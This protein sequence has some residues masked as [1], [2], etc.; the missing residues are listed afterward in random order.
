MSV[1][2]RGLSVRRQ[3][4]VVEED[5]GEEQD[6]NGEEAA[7]EHLEE[8][9]GGVFRTPAPLRKKKDVE[10]VQEERIMV[11]VRVRPL[12]ESERRKGNTI[13]WRWDDQEIVTKE[14]DVAGLQESELIAGI[15]DD[16]KSNFSFDRVFGPNEGNSEI[17]ETLVRPLVQRVVEGFNAAIL[18]Y[19]QTT[20]GK[21]YTISG[22][23]TTKGIVELA[24][25]DLFATIRSTEVSNEFKFV[26]RISYFEIYQ[27]VIQDLLDEDK[28]HLSVSADPYRGPR[29]GG[30][31]EVVVTSAGQALDILKRGQGSRKVGRTDMSD[32]SSRSHAIFQIVV[33]SKPRVLE[34]LMRETS[35]KDQG[36][37]SGMN[38]VENALRSWAKQYEKPVA[39]STLS[40]IDLAGSERVSKSLAK[41]ERLKEAGHI[42]KSLAELGNVIADINAGKSYVPFRNSKL[43]RLLSGA[44]GGNSY[45]A[46]IC[47]ISP[48]LIHH[49]E[50]RSTLQFAQR[51]SKVKT[52]AKVN[53][54]ENG[55]DLLDAFKSQ[56]DS[57]QRRLALN[58]NEKEQL[59]KQVSALEAKLSASTS[60]ETKSLRTP[61]VSRRQQFLPHTSKKVSSSRLQ[62]V[63]FAAESSISTDDEILEHI[64]ALEKALDEKEGKLRTA[65]SHLQIAQNNLEKLAAANDSDEERI[66][67]L[68]HRCAELEQSLE[69]EGRLSQQA[70]TDARAQ[71]QRHHNAVEKLEEVLRERDRA[72]EKALDTENELFKKIEELSELKANAEERQQDRGKLLGSLEALEQRVQNLLL[73]RKEEV[74]DLT[75]SMEELRQNLDEARMEKRNVEQ[76]LLTLQ[77]RFQRAT[78]EAEKLRAAHESAEAEKGTICENLESLREEVSAKNASAKELRGVVSR[79]EREKLELTTTNQSYEAKLTRL[80]EANELSNRE[81]QELEKEKDELVERIALLENLAVQVE[82]S[83][84]KLEALHAERER[85]LERVAQL[86][87]QNADLEKSRLHRLEALE[88]EKKNLLARLL[89][90]EQEKSEVQENCTKLESDFASQSV[91]VSKLQRRI[92]QQERDLQS[93]QEEKADAIL[94]RDRLGKE[95]ST[96][97]KH[98]QEARDAVENLQTELKLVNE[99]DQKSGGRIESLEAK[100]EIEKRKM[101]ELEIETD[102]AREELGEARQKEH[103]LRSDFEKLQR[104]MHTTTAELKGKSVEIASLRDQVSTMNESNS[105]RIQEMHK[106]VSE[107]EKHGSQAARKSALLEENLKATERRCR[108]LEGELAT[109]RQEVEEFSRKQDSFTKLR[110][111]ILFLGSMLGDEETDSVEQVLLSVQERIETHQEEVNLLRQT[112]EERSVNETVLQQRVAEQMEAVESLQL[113]VEEGKTREN[114]MQ[115]ELREKKEEIAMLRKE[116]EASKSTSEQEIGDLEA[117]ES[118]RQKLSLE[119]EQQNKELESLQASLEASQNALSKA[120][121]E[122]DFQR[123]ELEET[124]ERLQTAETRLERVEERAKHHADEY[125]SCSAKIRG[126]EVEL[127]RIREE[128]ESAKKQAMFYAVIAALH[129]SKALVE[130]QKAQKLMEDFEALRKAKDA[131]LATLKKQVKKLKKENSKLNS[132][133]DASKNVIHENRTLL[134]QTQQSL[135]DSI[136]TCE[137]L[138]VDLANAERRQDELE[139]ALQHAKDEKESILRELEETQSTVA[140]RLKKLLPIADNPESTNLK[141]LLVQLEKSLAK[142]NQVE[143]HNQKQVLQLRNEVLQ[144]KDALETLKVRYDNVE[145]INQDLNHELETF[146]H[147]NHVGRLHKFLNENTG[148]A[149]DRTGSFKKLE[150]KV[151]RFEKLLQDKDNQIDELETE[152]THLANQLRSQEQLQKEKDARFD[153]LKEELQKVIRERDEVRTSLLNV[154]QNQIES[155]EESVTPASQKRALEEVRKSA[156]KQIQTL[157][158]GNEE[159]RKAFDEKERHLQLVLGLF[160]ETEQDFHMLLDLIDKY[161]LKSDDHASKLVHIKS[162]MEKVLSHYRSK[163]SKRKKTFKQVSS[164]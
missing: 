94:E 107:A 41:G 106:L 152:A 123:R 40:L 160:D 1:R 102:R 10:L 14:I 97:G 38:D 64:S 125:V 48:A 81:M 37:T 90:L 139:I 95:V 136:A 96:L 100:L 62:N 66:D 5:E 7:Q 150:S 147:P 118:E 16:R 99:S 70:K 19:G 82:E 74:D 129:R 51:A 25:E 56:V 4:T 67:F 76:E 39:I 151:D 153:S 108:E 30:L 104:E 141:A 113:S 88:S 6:G 69:K 114:S 124:N 28:H 42:N 22:H 159:L 164:P 68:E 77:N 65:T 36:S 93:L 59:Q 35:S 119:F 58:I 33:E 101:G 32:E 149:T 98:L 3:P 112:I 34:N 47:C 91:E 63:R 84:G 105:S 140:N 137:S 89:Q 120:N 111:D 2:R 11:T 9:S 122:L 130:K 79:L 27:E 24:M 110:E 103:D 8:D 17:Y 146:R 127:K 161:S 23:G 87:G 18:A 85:L 75:K 15:P 132:N 72:Q 54:I 46:M 163:R 135:Q 31:T 162:Q 157:R 26:T 154:K 156:T 45:T 138:R 21:T 49:D 142:A 78:E 144:Q 20:S 115:N 117:A 53:Q 126:M 92:D 80:T 83:Q 145:K 109:S 131:F 43:T 73:E 71:E 158:K 52:H 134:K 86:E 121:H 61:H 116:L 44:L 12:I 50:S 128:L 155:K 13:S 55:D 143:K 148:S 60:P 133:K 29:V 57:L